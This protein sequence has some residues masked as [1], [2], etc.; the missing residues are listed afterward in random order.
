MVMT[1]MISTRTPTNNLN[2][3]TKRKVSFFS[4]LLSPSSSSL[5]SLSTDSTSTFLLN[6]QQ[7]QH[8]KLHNSSYLYTSLSPRSSSTL[9]CRRFY[10]SRAHPRPVPEF[11][12]PSAI[13]MV[14]D[15][16]EER[17]IRR[18]A[19]WERNKDKRQSKGIEV[20]VLLLLLVLQLITINSLLLLKCSCFKCLLVLL[21]MLLRCIYVY[22]V[23]LVEFWMFN[24][25]KI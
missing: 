7:Q 17:K 19:K 10:V 1:M 23:F 3:L 11:P 8:R 13:Q 20:S 5:L 16:V 18:A 2:L 12:V 6:R 4:S 14:L 15:D 21:C 24:L 9:P 22:F 25:K